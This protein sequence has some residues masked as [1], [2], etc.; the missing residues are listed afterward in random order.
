VEGGDG[1]EGTWVA[2]PELGRVAGAG[3]DG[4]LADRP[5]QLDRSRD[6]V[7]VAAEQLLDVSVPGGEITEAGLRGNVAVG[8]QYLESWLRGVGAAGISNLMEDAATAEI[9]RS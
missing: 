1:C 3:F 4:V 7:D 8:L 2:D 5:N 6:D 9:S